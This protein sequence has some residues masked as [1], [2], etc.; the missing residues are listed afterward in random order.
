MS[1]LP[2]MRTLAEVCEALGTTPEA[3]YHL[4]R[5]HRFPIAHTRLGS[6]Y[7][8]TDADVRAY[9]EH[10]EVTNPLLLEK[11]RFSKG[12]AALLAKVS[13]Q[14][15]ASQA[16]GEIGVLTIGPLAI[17]SFEDSV[18]PDVRAS[19]RAFAN[20]EIP[21]TSFGQRRGDVHER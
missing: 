15:A 4:L 12:R 20:R 5:R 16:A 18:P 3:A 10:R 11:R 14:T 8:F 7:R 21:S 6:T 17:V 19:L 13:A 9:V 2:K 1:A